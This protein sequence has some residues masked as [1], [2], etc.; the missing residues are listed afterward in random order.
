[1]KNEEDDS[2]IRVSER[3]LLKGMAEKPQVLFSHATTELNPRN[4]LHHF[5][6]SS[7][8]EESVIA[9]VPT[10]P[11]LPFATRPLCYSS[12]YSASMSS[13]INWRRLLL[14]P[15]TRMQFFLEQLEGEIFVSSSFSLLLLYIILDFFCWF[16]NFD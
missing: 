13:E 1:M 4:H 15:S 2:L 8:S 16:V 9:N 6:S 5:Y 7:S 14:L 12:S 3:D 11:L 10:T